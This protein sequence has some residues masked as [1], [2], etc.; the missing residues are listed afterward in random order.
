LPGTQ[1]HDVSC[2]GATTIDMTEAQRVSDGFNP[3]Q[4]DAVGPATQLVTLTL[5]ANDIGLMQILYGCTSRANIG[6]P[7]RDRYV[8]DGRDQI[9]NR[10]DSTAGKIAGVLRDIRR[11]APHARVFVL[12]Y[13]QI[14]PSIGRGC[15]PQVPITDGDVAYLRNEER[16]L[17]AVIEF[18]TVASRDFYVDAF[19][20][21]VG[22][23]AC[24]PASVRW[25]EPATAV[26]AAP[27]HPNESGM[28]ASARLLVEAMHHHGV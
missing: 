3:P 22:R 4:L 10:I 7:C 9:A 17:N 26:D 19:D 23:D 28:Q 14:L 13:L 21:S 20:A 11:R 8:S 16:R 6:T 5:G 1:L 27:M 12:A 24:Q 18:V 15:F 25:I 2:A